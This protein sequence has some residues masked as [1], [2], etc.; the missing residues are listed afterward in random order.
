MGGTDDGAEGFG[1]EE[2]DLA[3]K[4]SLKIK[5]KLEEL[6]LKVKL[7]RDGTEGNEYTFYTIYDKDGRVNVVG[8]SKAKYVFSIHLNSVTPAN[9]QRGVEVYA[10]PKTNLR[11]AKSLADNIVKYGK[12]QYSGLTINYKIDNGVYVRTYAEADILDANKTATR[13][14]YA[15]YNIT[16]DTPYLYMIRETGGIATGAYVDG[17]NK[18]FGKNLYYDS[19]IGVEAHLIELGYINHRADL[20]NML[21]NQDGYVYGI[22]QAIKDEIFE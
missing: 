16:T 11:L 19:N 21:N 14:S 9:S 22:V 6:G 13:K 1:Y 3:L 15:P 17:R 10:P 7:T 8:A 5:Q 4:F 12:T 20:Q 18:T 2:A